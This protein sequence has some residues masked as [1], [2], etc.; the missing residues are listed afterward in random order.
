MEQVELLRGG[1]VKDVTLY[2]LPAIIFD[3]TLSDD[4]QK[5]LVFY[6]PD[7]IYAP[8]DSSYLFSDK[9]YS[10][11]FL[12]NVFK[13]TF[14]DFNGD[15]VGLSTEYT[16]FFVSLKNTDFSNFSMN[17]V[18]NAT[19]MF[20]GMSSGFTFFGTPSGDPVVTQE[21]IDQLDFSNVK[22]FSGTFF[23]TTLNFD[24]ST[25]NMDSAVS[26]NFFMSNSYPAST[27]DI[28]KLQ[29]GSNVK[30]IAGL[31]GFSYGYTSSS[32]N[33]LYEKLCTAVE[34]NNI[35]DLSYFFAN[36][37]GDLSSFNLSLL[38]TRKATSYKGMFL[39]IFGMLDA[40]STTN[41]DVSGLNTSSIIDMS[42]MFFGQSKL[43]SLSLSN[44]NT[45][46]VKD[47]SWMFAEC[48][49]L[50]SLDVSNFDTSKVTDMSGMFSNCSGLTSLEI[51]FNTSNVTDMTEMFASCEGLISITFGSNFTTTNV[52]KMN[53]LFGSSQCEADSS[54]YYVDQENGCEKLT[55]I[56][57]SNFNLSNLS[58]DVIL[59]SSYRNHDFD[60][61]T[62]KAPTTIN[63]NHKIDLNC[64]TQ[65][66]SVTT[67]TWQIEGDTSG[68]TYTEITATNGT[69][70]KT[71][72]KVSAT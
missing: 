58:E 15:L 66:M 67:W 29:I 2:Y 64:Y 41:L 35:T 16:S 5:A 50:T 38:N 6:C 47:M 37:H 54:T 31:L 13:T 3:S 42:Y 32:I 10:N 25:I 27:M 40:T 55:M 22:N 11:L 56:N 33:T 44:F 34:A 19:A 24:L 28:S 62:I 45:S 1:G 4:S 39:N 46:S 7:T 36:Y 68:T 72:I 17:Y 30:H 63:A 61:T 52:K 8:V 18:E 69:L 51:L 60:I 43:T 23:L 59:F 9:I 70:G 49:G 26:L 53:Y 48:S 71:L 12:Y 20:A 21:I 14:D 65:D 57:L